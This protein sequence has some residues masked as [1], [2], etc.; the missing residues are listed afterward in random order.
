MHIL[1]NQINEFDRNQSIHHRQ[2]RHVY[3]N[4]MIDYIYPLSLY[5]NLFSLEC[6]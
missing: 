1:S 6:F 3:F 4:S 5:S 2:R